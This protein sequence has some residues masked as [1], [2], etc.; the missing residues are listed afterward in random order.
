MVLRGL[1]P[2]RHRGSPDSPYAAAAEIHVVSV[3]LRDVLDPE[4]RCLALRA[5][6][7]FTIAPSDVKLL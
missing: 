5:P 1:A 6:T 2:K 3:I 7:A 4:R